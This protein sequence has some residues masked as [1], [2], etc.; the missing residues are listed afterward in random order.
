MTAFVFVYLLIFH[1]VLHRSMGKKPCTDFK[2]SHGFHYETL[3]SR[4]VLD[5]PQ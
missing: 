1:R 3:T 4:S 5:C 2:V